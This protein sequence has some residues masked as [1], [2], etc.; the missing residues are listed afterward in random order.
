MSFLLSA[1]LL[2]LTLSVN[3]GGSWPCFSISKPVLNVLK[4]C[5]V[6][7]KIAQIVSLCKVKVM[8]HCFL[9]CIALPEFAFLVCFFFLYIYSFIY[10]YNL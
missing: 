4:K 9:I 5:Y 6:K 3:D 8:K 7:Y 2:K 1:M 10:F